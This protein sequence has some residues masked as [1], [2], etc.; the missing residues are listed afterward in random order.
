VPH[1][2]WGEVGVAY[3]VPAEGEE[4]AADDLGSFVGDRLAR[5]KIPKEFRVVDELPRTPYGKVVKG[6]LVEQWKKE[7]EG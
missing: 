4:V 1:G 3:V 5:Y 6:E 7:H 2:T